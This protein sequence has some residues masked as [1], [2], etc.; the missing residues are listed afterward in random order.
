MHDQQE[1]EK[2]K[3]TSQ[4]I[5][6]A[7]RRQTKEIAEKKAVVLKDLAKVEPAVRDAQQG[8]RTS[9]HNWLL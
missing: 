9:Y 1:A 2:K 8:E 6:E 3:A 5:Q 4:E 7:L